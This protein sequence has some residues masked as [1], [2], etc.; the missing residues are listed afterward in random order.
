MYIMLNFY[1]M[2]IKMQIK[3]NLSLFEHFAG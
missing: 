1:I 2:P 3:H